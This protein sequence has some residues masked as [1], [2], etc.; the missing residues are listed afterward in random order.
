MTPLMSD[1]TVNGET[2]TAGAIAAEAQLHPAPKGKPGIAWRAAGR[3]LTI[4]ALLLQ[5]AARLGLVPEPVSGDLATVETDDEALIR[6]VLDRA[7]DA[8]P[9]TET[10]IRTAYDANPGRWRAPTLYEAAHILFPVHPGDTEAL[11]KARATAETALAEITRNPRS[12]DQLARELSAC[13]SRSVGGRL[14]QIVTGDTVPEFEAALDGLNEGEVASAPVAT[15]FGLHIIRLD[16][17]AVGAV[18]PYEAVAPRIREALEKA[19]WARAAKAFTAR[20]S[21]KAC[22]TGVDLRAA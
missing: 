2:I 16:A 21:E 8:M 12:F 10:A 22:V 4:R 18:L 1:I 15:R 3:A 7:I 19:E 9:P 6:Q 17:R 13:S 5:E 14:G 11:T 20:L